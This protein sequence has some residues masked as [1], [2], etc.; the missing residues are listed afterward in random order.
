MYDAES[1]AALFAA[2]PA[3][4]DPDA[5]KDFTESLDPVSV[6]ELSGY[7]AVNDVAARDD[8]V[9]MLTSGRLDAGEFQDDASRGG[10]IV[11]FDRAGVQT[12]CRALVPV[13][14]VAATYTDLVIGEQGAVA[15]TRTAI[16]NK[17]AFEPQEARSF[18]IR[19]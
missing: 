3:E 17:G 19:R 8:A 14:S 2:A 1:V 12:A 18:S 6:C 9:Y 10:A 5:L 4:L 7:Q 11:K 16:G 15:A 13:S